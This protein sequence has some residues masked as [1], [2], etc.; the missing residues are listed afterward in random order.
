MATPNWYVITGGPMTGKTKL[1]EELAKLGYSTIPEAARTVIDSALNEGITTKLL[2]ANEKDFQEQVVRLKAEIEHNQNTEEATFFDRGMHDTL[3]Y[4]HHY[5]FTIEDW[6][7]RLIKEAHYKKVFLLEPL[8]EY[9]N[10]YARIEDS[11]FNTKIQPLLFS[12]YKEFGMQPIIVPDIGLEERLMFIMR[13]IAP[14]SSILEGEIEA[15]I[16]GRDQ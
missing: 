4:L 14:S 9:R 6:I 11:S 5:N 2:R 1:I 12:A 10:D 8:K 15:K 3:A 16:K 13:A 7:L